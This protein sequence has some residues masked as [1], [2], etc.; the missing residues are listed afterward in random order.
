MNYILTETFQVRMEGEFRL[1]PRVESED[2]GKSE[3]NFGG[4]GG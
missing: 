1:Q 2:K 4:H 3:R